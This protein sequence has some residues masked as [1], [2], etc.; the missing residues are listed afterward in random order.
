MSHHHF[1]IAYTI[2]PRREIIDEDAARDARRRLRALG[3]QTV[4]DIETTLLGEMTL[5]NSTLASR[6]KEAE[7]QIRDRVHEEL[8]GL[9]VLTRVK[10][11]G[12]L[13]VDGLG[14]AIRID[15]D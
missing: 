1:Q 12:S 14:E 4:P 3:W 5:F 9:Q 2:N 10:F 8:R 6:I 11:H 7:K 13:M 15:I